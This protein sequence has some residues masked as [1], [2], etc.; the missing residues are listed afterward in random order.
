MA[1]K[2]ILDQ[3]KE[4]TQKKLDEINEEFDKKMQDINEEFERKMAKARAKTDE[5]VEVNSKKIMNK[6]TTVAKMEAKNKLLKEK[7]ELIDEI[8]GE[9]LEKLSES[10]NYKSLIKEL[11]K[12]SAIK[13]D[14]V[15]L[16]PAKGKE[17]ETSEALSESGLSYKLADKSANIKS[18]FILKSGKIEINNSFDSILNKQLRDELELDIAKILF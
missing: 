6:M 17:K 3:I 9:A 12:R 14:D 7:R 18:G 2:D 16:I 15:K 5:Q 13:G 8:F 4:E 11:L 1:L 10:K